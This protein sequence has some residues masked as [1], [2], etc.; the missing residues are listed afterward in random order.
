MGE[1][2]YDCDISLVPAAAIVV[3]N[4]TWVGMPHDDRA[5]GGQAVNEAEISMT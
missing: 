4:T 3:V 1:L 2:C 5:S